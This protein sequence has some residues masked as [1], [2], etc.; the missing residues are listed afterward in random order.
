MMKADVLSG[1][2]KIFVCTG[3]KTNEG[4]IDYLPYDLSVVREPIY[5]EFSAW[6]EDITRVQK[7]KDIP[8]AL[9]EYI[10]FLEAELTIPIVIVSVGPNREQTIEL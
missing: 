6:S 4:D 2:D 3:Y 5:K 8:K 10:R 1:F 7:R 9:N